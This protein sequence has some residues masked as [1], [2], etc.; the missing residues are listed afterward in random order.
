MDNRLR[1]KLVELHYTK[2]AIHLGSALSCIDILS[3]LML[4]M[5]IPFKNVI[6]SKGHAASALYVVLNEL[7][8]ITDEE[9]STYYQNKSTLLAH[10]THESGLVDF[11]TGS[12]GHGISLACGKALARKLNGDDAKIFVIVSDG[13]M[14][15]GSVNE[16]LNFAAHHQLTNLVVICDNN[17]LQGMGETSAILGDLASE[18]QYKNGIQYCAVNGHDSEEL[19]SVLSQSANAPVFINAKTTK[20]KGLNFAEGNNDWHYNQLSEQDYKNAIAQL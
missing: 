6:L 7:G 16:A 19:L 20:G 11:S 18:I 8:E 5:A 14:N 1:K 12:L 17:G 10:P 9:L 4:K 2:G 3:T 15:E 13:E